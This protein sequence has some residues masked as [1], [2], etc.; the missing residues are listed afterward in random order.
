MNQYQQSSMLLK[1]LVNRWLIPVQKKRGDLPLSGTVINE[2]V[3]PKRHA[4]KAAGQTL[5]NSSPEI[6]ETFHYQI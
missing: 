6:E 1:L 3:S 2:S 4:A 5:A